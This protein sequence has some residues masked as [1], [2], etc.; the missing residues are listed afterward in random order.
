MVEVVAKGSDVKVSDED[1]LPLHSTTILAKHQDH[2]GANFL[3]VSRMS[4]QLSC[5]LSHSRIA[6]LFSSRRAPNFSAT[7]LNFHLSLQKNDA[8]DARGRWWSIGTAVR[9]SG[10]AGST[11][12][13][14]NARHCQFGR[15]APRE[16][17]A[18]PRPC[19]EFE[20]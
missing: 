13:N 8:A 16:F 6:H 15:M 17:D 10:T 7:F 19:A 2:A 4:L 11:T 5:S 20:I 12:R 14:P 9:S 1:G 18:G 3:T